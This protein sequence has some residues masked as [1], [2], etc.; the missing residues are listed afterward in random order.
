LKSISALVAVSVWVCLSTGL[1]AAV[2]EVQRNSPAVINGA[3]Y[4]ASGKPLVMPDMED[5]LAAF[6]MTR[7]R[8]NAIA[9]LTDQSVVEVI[10]VDPMIA[11]NADAIASAEAANRQDVT[12]LQAAIKA[13]GK[14]QT[15]LESRD[16]EIT[17]VLAADIM[18]GGVLVLYGLD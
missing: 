15:D 11:A 6:V 18:P 5:I 3:L 12:Q 17:T 13:N 2:I 7:S 4:P 1:Q 14:L 9:N 10:V 8:L 16:V